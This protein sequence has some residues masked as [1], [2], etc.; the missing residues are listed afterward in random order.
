MHFRQTFSG[1][2]V[3]VACSLVSCLSERAL[4]RELNLS[5]DGSYAP[6]DPNPPAGQS[7]WNVVTTAPEVGIRPN[8]PVA[9]QAL[10]DDNLNGG[11]I[12]LNYDYGS[13]RSAV[14]E[15][16]YTINMSVLSPG[17]PRT[18]FGVRD[19][20]VGGGKLIMFAHASTGVN[21][22]Y[23]D[24]NASSVLGADIYTGGVDG[25]SLADGALHEY[26]MVKYDNAGELTV[27]FYIDSVIYDSRPYSS[28]ADASSENQGVGVFTT[29]PGLSN[30]IVDQL[31]FT[32]TVVPEPTCVTMGVYGLALTLLC[33]PRLCRNVLR[34]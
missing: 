3:F 29:T 15:W 21:L 22:F 10:F 1:A 2:A 17:F 30:Y 27:D 9:G 33:H 32:A 19:E 12:Q 5:Y 11:R 25:P 16:E 34:H 24:G 26:R 4:A 8:N 6:S 28:F 7:T 20:G 18:I 23:L 31:T 14:T 13:E